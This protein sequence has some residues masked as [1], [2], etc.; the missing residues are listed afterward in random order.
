MMSQGAFASWQPP[1][2]MK[3]IMQSHENVPEGSSLQAAVNV[4]PLQDTS[5]VHSPVL[6]TH[7]LG[8]HP[9]PFRH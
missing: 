6:P 7:V 2:D 4:V 8:P 1:I 3:L 9:P 5:Q